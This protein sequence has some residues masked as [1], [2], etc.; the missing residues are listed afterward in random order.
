MFMGGE[1]KVTT[2]FYFQIVK[3]FV[4]PWQYKTQAEYAHSG[5]RHDRVAP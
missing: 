1:R 3:S 5:M 4:S 2:I